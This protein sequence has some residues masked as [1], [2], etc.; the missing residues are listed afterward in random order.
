MSLISLGLCK[1]NSS[2]LSCVPS[3]EPPSSSFKCGHPILNKLKPALLTLQDAQLFLTQSGSISSKKK[4]L[5]STVFSLVSTPPRPIISVPKISERLSSNLELRIHQ[6]QSPLMETG[7]SHLTLPVMHTSSH[8]LTEQK[9]LNSTKDTFC[10]SS[11]PS[12]SLNILGL[13]PLTNLSGSESQSGVTYCYLT[14]TSLVTSNPCTSTTLVLLN[15]VEC[16]DLQPL[17]PQIDPPA[18]RCNEACQNWNKGVCG[19]EK[20]CFYLHVCVLC[21]KKGHT[22]DKCLMK[23]A[24]GSSGSQSQVARL[25]S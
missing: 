4:P 15:Q 21:L 16:P 13:S 18:Q 25:G 11:P 24:A 1:I 9:N 20:N 8:S 7:P 12:E 2:D 5:I 14:L 17:F 6:N 22:S 10:N 23:G 19:Q 3:Y